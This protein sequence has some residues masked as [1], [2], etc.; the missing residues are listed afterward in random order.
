MKV[1]F[2]ISELGLGWEDSS[3]RTIHLRVLRNLPPLPLIDHGSSPPLSKNLISFYSRNQPPLPKS[4]Y[5][6]LVDTS[7]ASVKRK[8]LTTSNLSSIPWSHVT[9]PSLKPHSL[10]TSAFHWAKSRLPPLDPRP[11]TRNI[12]SSDLPRPF[13]PA[14]YLTSK[15]Y[16]SSAS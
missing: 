10:R 8:L 12:A 15:P 6:F 7:K 1:S 5:T 2:P 4:T 16:L 13:S 11:P 14:A 3:H 9:S